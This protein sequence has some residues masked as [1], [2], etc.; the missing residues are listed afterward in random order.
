V[1]TAAIGL[2][3]RR[4]AGAVSASALPIHKVC[5]YMKRAMTNPTNGMNMPMEA[6]NTE[7]MVGEP[8]GSS[9][10]QARSQDARSIMCDDDMM[11]ASVKGGRKILKKRKAAATE[12]QI[13]NSLDG[14]TGQEMENRFFQM[15]DVKFEGG[16]FCGMCVRI[17]QK[18]GERQRDEDPHRLTQWVEHSKKEIMDFILTVWLKPWFQSMIVANMEAQGENICICK[19]CSGFIR[20][21]QRDKEKKKV[22]KNNTKPVLPMFVALQ[23]ILSGGCTQS[24]CFKMLK[25]C[26]ESLCHRFPTNPILQAKNGNLYLERVFERMQLIAKQWNVFF[27]HPKA[28][29]EDFICIARWLAEGSQTFMIDS[30][31]SRKMRKIMEN[32]PEFKTWWSERVPPALACRHHLTVGQPMIGKLMQM[33]VAPQEI[34]EK[35]SYSMV[36]AHESFF[37]VIP[38]LEEMKTNIEKVPYV[39]DQVSCFCTRCNKVSVLSYEYDVILKRVAGGWGISPFREIYYDGMVRKAKNGT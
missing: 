21:S 10:G 28:N 37:P 13:L 26:V 35:A 38:I 14:G 15:L 34:K 33:H 23:Y 9:T 25:H 7:D 18:E 36:L 30:N 1:G 20:R 16:A 27:K 6:M 17:F 12:L 29:N 31:L 8:S 5:K 32:T 39:L 3:R 19:A 11:L 22:K 4:S 2:V 24:P